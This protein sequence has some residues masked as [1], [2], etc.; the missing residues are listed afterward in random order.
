MI[1]HVPF[2]IYNNI[3]FCFWQQILTDE[4]IFYSQK[5]TQSA[6]KNYLNLK[7]YSPFVSNITEY[8][9]TENSV[10]EFVFSIKITN[11]FYHN[12]KLVVHYTYNKEVI[13]DEIKIVTANCYRKVSY[14]LTS[15]HLSDINLYIC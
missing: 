5:I 9:S 15:V 14:F 11:E 6:K 13:A 4:G 8:L 10:D 1:T 12:T 7:D 3:K 2:K